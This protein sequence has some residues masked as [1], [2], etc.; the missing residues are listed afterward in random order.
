LNLRKAA[1]LGRKGIKIEEIQIQRIHI[2]KAVKGTNPPLEK[3]RGRNSKKNCF[4]A[5][6]LES[7]RKS[8][9][10]GFNREAAAKGGH[11]SKDKP[12]QSHPSE[13]SRG[14]LNTKP[15]AK[16]LS[17]LGVTKK[18]SSEAQKLA[19]KSPEELQAEMASLV[20]CATMINIFSGK[21][22]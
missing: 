4:R 11:H 19:R 13:K 14:D 8:E 10:H 6:T 17:E 5:R 15:K 3:K 1:N 12:K 21:T 22:P 7:Y 16:K 18:E 9:K 20:L 2:R